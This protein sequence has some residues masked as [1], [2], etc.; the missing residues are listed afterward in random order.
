VIRIVYTITICLEFLYQTSLV[1][2]QN[3]ISNPSFESYHSCPP[4]TG[5]LERAVSWESI[6]GNADYYHKCGYFGANSLIR[7]GGG[8]QTP[9]SGEAYMGL[10]PSGYRITAQ[11]DSFPIDYREYA[12]NTLAEPLERRAQYIF[13]LY[14]SLGDRSLYTS[15]NLSVVGFMAKPTWDKAQ[16]T[17]FTVK[18]TLVQFDTLIKDTQNWV[19]LVDTFIADSAYNFISIGVFTDSTDIQIKYVNPSPSYTFLWPGSYY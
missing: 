4:G 8:F 2:S 5:E 12:I 17:P 15:N 13:E 10:C 11:K 3:L 9:R 19:H 14:L 6:R 16:L 7:N 18:K 1:Y